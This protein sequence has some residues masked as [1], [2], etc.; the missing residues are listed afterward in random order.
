MTKRVVN[1]AFVGRFTAIK[2]AGDF[3]R[4][5]ENVKSFISDDYSLE[6][7]VC[8]LLTMDSCLSL[9]YYWNLY[10]YRYATMYLGLTI[11]M[12]IQVTYD[13][14]TSMENSVVTRYFNT[15]LLYVI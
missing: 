10:N 12:G 5:V 13:I 7:Q 14:F 3:L 4:A 15:V 2:G 8:V 6:F 9:M 1:V 11:G